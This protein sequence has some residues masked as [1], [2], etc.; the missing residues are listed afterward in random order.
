[1]TS[2]RRFRTFRP[3][4]P[5]SGCCSSTSRHSQ[6]TS[7]SRWSR[8]C[9]VDAAP[10]AFFALR[11]RHARAHAISLSRSCIGGRD[12]HTR[13]PAHTRARTRTRA[14]AHC[15]LPADL[16]PPQQAPVPHHTHVH[17]QLTTPLPAL[18]VCCVCGSAPTRCAL[19]CAPHAC[20]TLWAH[21]SP[22]AAV[23]SARAAVCC[24]CMRRGTVFWGVCG[25]CAGSLL[26]QVEGELPEALLGVVRLHYIDP[27][28]CPVV[29]LAP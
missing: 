24:R 8:R 9:V 1:M 11:P 26:G 18:H 17:P 6:L 3:S 5:S 29:P 28:K 22:L 27:A 4:A 14:R 12:V 13:A 15:T 21:P 10:T 20:L 23:Y 2:P 19:G 16:F 7:R 25:A